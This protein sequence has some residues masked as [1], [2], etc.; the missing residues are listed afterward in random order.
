MSP[1]APLISVI[2]V[3]YNNRSTIRQ[4]IE[5][6][7]SQENAAFEYWVIDGGSTDGTLEIIEEYA[8]RLQYI[9]EPDSGLYYAMNKGWQK[10]KGDFVG[11]LNADDFYNGSQ[12]LALISKA[13]QSQPHIAAVYGD[14][15]YVKAEDTRQIVRY[16]KSGHYSPSQFLWGWMPP[17]PTFYVRKALFEKFG[18]FRAEEFR[19]AADYELMLRFLYKHR[20]PAAYIPQVFVRMRVGGLSNRSV[21]NRVRGNAEDRAAWKINELKPYF[22]TLLAKPL[23]K[24]VQFI[25]KPPHGAV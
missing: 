14:L 21:R 8:G 9:S 13:V 11:F 7:L 16:W 19:S 2:T 10:A 5:S 3:S 23:R 1:K 6:V 20:A 15:A 12:V 22:F 25:Q 4:T 17:H 24:L 18:G